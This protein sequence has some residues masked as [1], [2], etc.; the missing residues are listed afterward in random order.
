M[1]KNVVAGEGFEPSKAEADRFI[2]PVVS[3]EIITSIGSSFFFLT[4]FCVPNSSVSTVLRF[5]GEMQDF[6]F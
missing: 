3:K 2:D 1:V 5:H 6:H 4:I